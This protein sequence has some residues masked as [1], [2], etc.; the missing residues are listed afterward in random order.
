MRKV[1]GKNEVVECKSDENG[2][3]YCE[4]K[5]KMKDGEMPKVAFIKA[6][7]VKGTLQPLEVKG[8]EEHLDKLYNFMKKRVIPD[9]DRI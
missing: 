9:G 4:L 1:L 6:A 3:V 5:V 7:I 2:H 8:S